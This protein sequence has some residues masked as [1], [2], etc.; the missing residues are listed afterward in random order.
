MRRPPGSPG[1][2]LLLAELAGDATLLSLPRAGLLAA[3]R[4]AVR[5]PPGESDD[6]GQGA[7]PAKGLTCEALA[8]AAPGS[9][10]LLLRA[11]LW[12]H[13]EDL[14]GAEHTASAL[15]VLLRQDNG[16]LLEAVHD[17]AALAVLWAGAAAGT[18]L[19][20]EESR[21]GGGAGGDG[22]AERCSGRPPRLAVPRQSSQAR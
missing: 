10:K 19:F 5:T 12:R 6:L 8:A 21:V 3:Q 11:A 14:L 13:V 7:V 16:R 18:P 17:P 4:G 22:R 15:D 2:A 20:D 9:Q 1:E